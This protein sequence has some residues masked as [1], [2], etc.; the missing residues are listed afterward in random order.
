MTWKESPRRVRRGLFF[1]G[2]IAKKRDTGSV[3]AGT[4]G[5][6]NGDAATDIDGKA[7]VAR[8]G[9]AVYRRWLRV[10]SLTVDFS[11]ASGEEKNHDRA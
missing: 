11:R 3:G 7:H 6:G 4:G 5:A 10:L 1:P 9:F 2:P 8:A